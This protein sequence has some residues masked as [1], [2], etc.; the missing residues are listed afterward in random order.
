MLLGLMR[1][2]RPLLGAPMLGGTAARVVPPPPAPVGR[3]AVAQLN[4]LKALLD[5]GALTQEEFAAAKRQVL[6]T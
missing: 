6:G 2:R 5:A 3:T 4:D 1:R